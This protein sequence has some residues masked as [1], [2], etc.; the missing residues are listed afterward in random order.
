MKRVNEI[1]ETIE[2]TWFSG[3]R[4]ETGFLVP[5]VP[6]CRR[7]QTA[8]ARGQS[9]VEFALVLPLILLLVDWCT[10]LLIFTMWPCSCWIRIR[11]G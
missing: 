9:L 2:K 6:L 10:K 11:S 3:L 5:N 7:E 8:N 1:V 4:D